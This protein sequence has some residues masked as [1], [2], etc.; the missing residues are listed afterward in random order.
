MI[1]EDPQVQF[2][3]FYRFNF[4]ALAA[5]YGLRTYIQLAERH[6]DNRKLFFSNITGG[7]GLFYAC[8]FSETG[9]IEPTWSFAD[10]L[11]ES[12][13]TEDLKFSRYMYQGTYIDPDTA[14]MQ[15]LFKT[16]HHE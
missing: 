15:I 2:R 10:T 4:K 7:Y 9:D 1:P 16:F 14:N 8:N 6:S 3:W 5:D 13:A 11:W 12:P